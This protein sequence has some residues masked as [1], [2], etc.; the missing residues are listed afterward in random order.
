RLNVPH[1]TSQNVFFGFL[2]QGSPGGRRHSAG[3]SPGPLRIR[4]IGLH[5]RLDRA[6]ASAH[7]SARADK[8][9]ASSPVKGG[10]MRSK[11][12]CRLLLVIAGLSIFGVMESSSVFAQARRQPPQSDQKKNKRPG[13]GQQQTETGEKQEPLP[14]DLVN[15][16]PQDMRSSR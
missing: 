15:K 1:R 7:N 16:K 13:E 8:R 11:Y 14:P 9:P 12:V 10:Y 5:N 2:R 4:K 3:N 6:N